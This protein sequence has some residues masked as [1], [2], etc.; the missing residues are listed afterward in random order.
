MIVLL[1]KEQ[2]SVQTPDAVEA[3]MKASDVRFRTAYF[4]AVDIVRG[5]SSVSRVEALL[6]S[7]E[8]DA[9]RLL[10][11][12]FA[13]PVSPLDA[14]GRR[15]AQEWS[16][17]FNVAADA[18]A[19]TI[20]AGIRTLADFDPSAGSAVARMVTNRR[21][22]ITKFVGVQKA[23]TREAVIEGFARGLDPKSLARTIRGSIGLSERQVQSVN[24]FRRLVTEGKA[25][26]LRRELRDKR[27]DRTLERAIEGDLKLT[28]GQIDRMVSRYEE[29]MLKYRS[30][31]IA[32]TE[33]LR[34]THEGTE[35]MFQQAIETGNIDGESLERKWN[36]SGQ[37]NVRG[38]H[39]AMQGQ[40]RPL[41]EPFLTGKGN[42]LQRPGDPDAPNSETSQCVC[43]VSTRFRAAS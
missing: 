25:A 9:T 40:K 18:T 43:A 19:D 31:T 26:A 13:R 38:S 37:E 39:Q 7:G 22:L 5:S 28:E 17:S 1:A 36:T 29:R 16:R 6:R 21:R 35:E 24:N 32:R 42:L 15:L 33:S 12:G 34:A 10:E 8:L 4:D 30:E 23:A 2:W 20:S 27:F 14:A 3:L 41:G 11:G